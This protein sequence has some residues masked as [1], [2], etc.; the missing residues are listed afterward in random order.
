MQD[1]NPMNLAWESLLYKQGEMPP[2]NPQELQR[3]AGEVQVMRDAMWALVPQIE[4]AGG[5]S[6]SIAYAIARYL[7]EEVDNLAY[8]AKYAAEEAAYSAAEGTADPSQ[9]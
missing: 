7:G 4:A 6:A 8:T 5:G 1:S 9:L 2:I 3:L